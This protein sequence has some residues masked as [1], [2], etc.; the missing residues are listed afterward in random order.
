VVTGGGNGAFMVSVTECMGNGEG[1]WWGRA[2]SW[3]ARRLVFAMKESGRGWHG[4]AQ[5]GSRW[6][7]YWELLSFEGGRSPGQARP[8][9]WTQRSTG[10]L[11]KKPFQRKRGLAGHKGRMACGPAIAL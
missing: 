7:C 8:N 3:E 5:L 9:R 2:I 6:R 11:R 4:G 1:R 10:R